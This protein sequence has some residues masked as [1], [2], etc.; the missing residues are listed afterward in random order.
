MFLPFH[1]IFPKGSSLYPVASG[2]ISAGA[3]LLDTTTANTFYGGG[4]DLTA[5]Q[6]GNHILA[7]YSTTK[8]AMAWISA[9]APSGLATTQRITNG[10]NEAAKCNMFESRVT[11][12]R[13]NEQNHTGAGTYSNKVIATDTSERTSIVFNWAA[14]TLH[15]V[16]VWTY[17]PTGQTTNLEVGYSGSTAISTITTKDAWVNTTFYA[18]SAQPI[19]IGHFVGGG[20]FNGKYFYVDDISCLNITMPV[21]TGALLLSTKAGSR[22]WIQNTGVTGNEALTYKVYMQ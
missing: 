2:S 21:A 10:D 4:V 6:D 3:A 13:S 12:A 1:S 17:L 14:G 22:G 20:N 9:T 18:T 7:L 16:D 11:S 15:L 19:S 5:Y 8:Q